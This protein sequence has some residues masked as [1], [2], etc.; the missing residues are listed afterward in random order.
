MPKQWTEEQKQA[1]RDRYAAKKIAER[2][3]QSAI[4]PAEAVA[5]LGNPEPAPA[6]GD[7]SAARRRLLGDQDPEVAALVTDEE[8]A[9]WLNE[10][11]EAAIL[12]QKKQLSTDI[13]ARIKQEAR[14]EHNLIPANQ[15]RSEAERKRLNEKL[16]IR[17]NLPGEG[18]GHRGSNG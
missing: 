2:E 9:K 10:E 3:A 13:R 7:L 17:F 18:A 16:E 14:A 4:D 15:L 12:E 11:R 1:A 5:V 8:L 6:L